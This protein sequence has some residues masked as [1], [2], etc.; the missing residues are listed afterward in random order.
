MHHHK[1]GLSAILSHLYSDGTERPI[2]YASKIIPESELH[3]AAID[4][5]AGAIIFGF[6]KILQLCIR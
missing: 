5:E 2:A 4:K 6:K 3:R 1:Y